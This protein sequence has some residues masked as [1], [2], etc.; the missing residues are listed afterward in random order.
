MAGAAAAAVVL[1]LD[2]DEQRVERY[3]EPETFLSYYLVDPSLNN[4][5]RW[6]QPSVSMSE[7]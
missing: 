3:D 1:G 6:L 7:I 4:L 5:S 2:S